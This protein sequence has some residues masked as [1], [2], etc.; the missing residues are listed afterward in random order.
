MDYPRHKERERLMMKPDCLFSHACTWLLV[1]CALAALSVS[2]ADA[3]SFVHPGLLQSRQDLARIRAGV[4]SG[5]GPIAAG[6]AV[7]R[8]DPEPQATYVMHGPFA[9]VGRNPTIHQ[10]DFDQDANAAYQCAIMWTITKNPAYADKSREIL[11]A[12]SSTLTTI[13]GADAV[14]MAGLGPFKM[15]NAAEILRYTD[16][17]WSNADT[18]GCEHLFRQVVYP[19]LKDF[20]LFANGNWDGAAVKTDMAIGVFCND[21]PMF[22]RALRY[23]VNGAGDGRLTHYI[24]PN[25]Q[26]QESG[27]DQ[28]HTQLGLG[29][30]GDCC[31]IAWNQG[32]DLYAYADNRLLKG[33]EYTAKYNLGDT[34]SF[35]PD[36]DRTGKYA[37]QVISPIGRGKFRPIYEQVY[38]HYVNVAGLTAPETA[39][40]VARIRPEGAG[41]WADG[42]G[43]GTLL[44]ALP[45]PVDNHPA[46]PPMAPG[47]L[48]AQGAA[49]AIRLTWVASVGATYYTVQR[50]SL[51]GGHE[52]VIALSVA[53][54]SYIDTHVKPGRL[55]SYIISASNAAGTSPASLNAS[56]SAGLPSPWGHQDIG[57][58]SV[59]GHTRFDGH[60]FTLEG[61]GTEIGG[62]ADE[63]QFACV[64]LSGNGTITARFVP[65]VSS[66]FSQMGLMIRQVLTPDAPN[67]SLLLTPQPSGN[68][69]VPGWK[70]ALVTRVSAGGSTQPVAATPDLSAPIVTYGR[71][72]RPYWLRLSYSG[73]TV[74]G[75]V[76]SDGKHWTSVGSVGFS[77]QH[78]LFVGL[79]AC[80]DR[81]QITTTVLFDQ[82]R[83]SD[84]RSA[85][86]S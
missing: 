63:C 61:A 31:Q 14:L 17:A 21:R 76:S 24:Y 69:E 16:P 27:R 83:V 59:P 65:Q 80:S 51:P 32:L 13:S 1:C 41:P 30:L 73:D 67:V 52:R 29:H 15:V 49:G 78:R 36:L 77:P 8:K 39:A 58:V 34:V 11:H 19:V 71:L 38:N 7:F 70:V 68:V 74:S 45:D 62:T 25:G 18:R 48:L 6:F 64:P 44:Y 26:C 57:A 72:M 3:Q 42:T 47:G 9:Q 33:F 79:A 12:W 2:N 66:Q 4:A 56:V 82:V 60:T 20:A 85:K 40:V 46:A 10:T 37:H 28:Q 54:P 35:T 86:E 22:E 75:L 53:N 43:F 50:A 23:Y 81:R 5:S 84:A 55:Y